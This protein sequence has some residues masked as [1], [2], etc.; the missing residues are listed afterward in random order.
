MATRLA[1]QVHVPAEPGRPPDLAAEL[2]GEVMHIDGV[3][4]FAAPR[5]E[6]FAALTDPAVMASAMPG[7]REWDA[8]DPDRWTILVKLPLPLSPVL[9]IAVDVDERDSPAHARLRAAGAGRGGGARVDT[10][11]DLDEAAP[12]RTSMRWAA[13]VELSGPLRALAGAIVE[14]VARRQA[15][16]TLDA[17]AKRVEAR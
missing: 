8:S 4:E 6:V 17:I 9:R 5:D 7:V 11:F 3:R 16:R 2:G 1:S 15:E 14:P 10:S 13:E 12:E